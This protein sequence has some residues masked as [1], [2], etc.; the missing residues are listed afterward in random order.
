MPPHLRP[1]VLL[2]QASKAGGPE[3]WKPQPEASESPLKRSL[4][5]S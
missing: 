1:L 5:V 4:E 2:T 3:G